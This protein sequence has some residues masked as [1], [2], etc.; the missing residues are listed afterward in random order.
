M[1][2]SL[3]E[4]QC[5]VAEKSRL[6]VNDLRDYVGSG[7]RI[8]ATSSFQTHSLPMLHILASSGI[9]IPIVFINTG[10]LF[11]ESL[12][13]RDSIVQMLGLSLIDLRPNVPKSEQ[14]EPDGRLWFA[15]DT[16]KCCYFNKVEPMEPFLHK[17]DV[18]V[19]GVRAEQSAVRSNFR[20]E[21]RGRHGVV[22][23]HPMLDW[24]AREIFA[25][26]KT[27]DLP[28]HPLDAQGYSSIGCMPC[29]TKL[30]SASDERSGRWVGQQKTE[31]GLHT[32]LVVDSSSREKL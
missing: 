24:S 21:Q 3:E 2:A 11:P 16:G 8:F 10:Y 17:Y 15:A 28:E 25:Y 22:R 26:R 30:T 4:V 13:F 32:E 31:C 23:Y 14:R 9:D 7:K 20:K 12:S 1:V 6:I 27:H 5:A 29:T 18:W 19:S